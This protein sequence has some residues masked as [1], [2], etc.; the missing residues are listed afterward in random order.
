MN[1]TESSK[2]SSALQQRCIFYLGKA[3]R[4]SYIVDHRRDIAFKCHVIFFGALE[5]DDLRRLKK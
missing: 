2:G 5:T 3:Q 4:I 1:Y